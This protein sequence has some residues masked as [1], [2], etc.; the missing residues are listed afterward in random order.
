MYFVRTGERKNMNLFD[1]LIFDTFNSKV[2]KTDIINNDDGYELFIDMPGVDKKNINL[3]FDNEYLTVSVKN[4]EESNDVKYLRKE[5]VSHSYSRSY[6]LADSDG[7]NIKA[8]LND[9]VLV[10]TIGKL[11]EVNKKRNIFVE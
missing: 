7:D 6:Y 5:R 2:M 9:G 10:I 8:K 4:S 3:D 1:S 11:K